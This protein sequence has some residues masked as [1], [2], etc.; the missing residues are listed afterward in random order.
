[1]RPALS[2]ETRAL[3]RRHYSEAWFDQKTAEWKM[4]E[5]VWDD[6]QFKFNEKEVKGNYDYL[7]GGQN[8]NSGS[9]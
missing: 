5:F 4:D 1:M 2:A 9:S 8:N 7:V 3:F 6:D